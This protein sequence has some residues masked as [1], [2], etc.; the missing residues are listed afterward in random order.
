[1]YM[2]A[3]VHVHVHVCKCTCTCTCRCRCRCISICICMCFCMCMC[4]CICIRIRICICICIVLCIL[5]SRYLCSTT[6]NSIAKCNLDTDT[7][8]N[9]E[10]PSS[11]CTLPAAASARGWRSPRN[12][13]QPPH[14]YLWLS[15][16]LKK[17]KENKHYPKPVPRV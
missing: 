14:K 15:F 1:M 6:G 13:F 8:P 4:I 9:D 3:D 5:T 7:K 17:I 12:R 11:E 16:R 10:T 2:Y